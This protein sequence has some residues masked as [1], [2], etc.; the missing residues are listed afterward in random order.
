MKKIYFF[1]LMTISFNC[2]AQS[3]YEIKFTGANDTTKYTAFLVYYNEN[4]AYMRIKYY[5]PQRQYRVVQVKYTGSSG[6]Y[7]NGESYFSIT[8]TDVTYITEKSRD[9]SY[10]PDYFVWIG[11]ERLPYTTDVEP[12]ADGRRT[13]HQVNAHKKLQVS[14]LTDRYLNSFFDDSEPDF[15][16]LQRM[17]REDKIPVKRNDEVRLH[18]IIAANT[19]ISD[20]GAGCEVDLRNLT[21]EFQAIANTLNIPFSRYIISGANFS[22]QQLVSEI[23]GLSIGADDVVFFIYR[24]HGFRWSNQS[25]HYPAL[26]LTTSHLTPVTS[27]N[28]ILLETI[29]NTLVAKGGALNI[30]M[31]DCCNSNIGVPQWSTD[32]YLYM[33]AN[34]SADVQKLSELFLNRKGNLI[35]SASQEGEVSWTN[36]VYGGFFTTSFLQ[37]LIEE[38]SYMKSTES[39]WV[40]IINNTTAY[41][42]EK[43]VNCGTCSAQNAI[44]QNQIVKK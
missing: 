34:A 20:I 12:D 2:Y 26:A 31:A 7:D 11:D 29:Y 3:L 21:N 25:S 42:R 37:A 23:N 35:F 38:T 27:N 18:L 13:V 4:D 28:T 15:L 39:S 40:N 10:N 1:L 6:K 41:A 9:E 14:E 8:G 22:K 19:S 36:S 16:A 33:Q 17:A 24:G 30:V 44:N 32:N 43:S 5:N